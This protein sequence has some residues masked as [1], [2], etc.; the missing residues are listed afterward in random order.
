MKKNIDSNK[1][2]IREFNLEILIN[3]E[4]KV[5]FKNVNSDV[6]EIMNNLDPE[7]ENIKKRLEVINKTKR[8]NR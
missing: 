3:K 6:I 4:G 2:K 7:N 1:S 8:S 5:S